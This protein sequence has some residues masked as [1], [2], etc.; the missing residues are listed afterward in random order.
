MQG[1]GIQGEKVCF[2]L[3]LGTA[4][5]KS[6]IYLHNVCGTSSQGDQGLRG[7]RGLHGPPGV[8]GPS[9]P[10]VRILSQVKQSIITG[11]IVSLV[12]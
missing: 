3:F 7:I 11:I 2:R 5:L 1:I 4:C 9:G 6:H 8:A 12:R 10:K